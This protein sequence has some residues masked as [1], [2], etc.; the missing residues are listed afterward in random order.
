MIFYIGWHQPN[1]GASGPGLFEHSMISVN[2]LI[3]RKAD[4]EVN[5]WILDS[6]AFTRL[7][8]KKGHLS[9]KI[10]AHLIMRWAKCGNLEAAVSQDY[11]C[12]PVVLEATGLNVLTHQKLSV[13]R[14]EN[15]RK[16]LI[17]ESHEEVFKKPILQETDPEEIRCRLESYTPPEAW[18]EMI[19]LLKLPV[20]LMPVLQG[21]TPEEYVQHID[22][23]E[24]YLLEGDWLGVGSLTQ[25][26]PAQIEEILQ[27]VT[28][29]T[30]SLKL[31]LHGF[32][33]KR[34]ALNHGAVR[35]YLYSADSQAAGLIAGKGSK[36]YKD[37]NSPQAALD[38]AKELQEFQTHLDFFG[39]AD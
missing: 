32:G 26:S 39:T 6:G 31:R 18:E 15:L 22:I 1:N 37:S 35:N 29:A 34:K 10:Y 5:N 33:V 24:D 28:E 14:Y 12:A 3:N 19:F 17:R 8:S 36:K 4:F 16:L 2:R 9:T 11:L 20:Y 27:A 25:K 38:Y 13:K 30:K 21:T 23:Y 7:V